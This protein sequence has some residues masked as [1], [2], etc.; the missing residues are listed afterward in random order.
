MTVPRDGNAPGSLPKSGNFHHADLWPPLKKHHEN[1]MNTMFSYDWKPEDF[2]Q[3]NQGGL[4]QTVGA[5]GG[6]FYIWE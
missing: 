4:S 5:C 2:P 3:A 6:Y 1:R